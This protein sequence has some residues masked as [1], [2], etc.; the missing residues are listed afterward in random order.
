MQRRGERCTEPRSSKKLL[1]RQQPEGL[2]IAVITW[3]NS[4]RKESKRS[5]IP[6]L[7]TGEIE[8]AGGKH[9]K[10]YGTWRGTPAFLEVSNGMGCGLRS[11]SQRIEL[12]SRGKSRGGM[13]YH[14][15]SR[16]YLSL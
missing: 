1:E 9:P 10:G 16:E 5:I 11:L 14:E 6:P 12:V 7:E 15:I 2:V 13:A 4:V 3:G 8:G